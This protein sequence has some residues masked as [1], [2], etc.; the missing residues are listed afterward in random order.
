[1]LTNQTANVGGYITFDIFPVL[2]EGVS[3][4]QPI[5]LINPAG[6]FRLTKDTR[7]FD[8]DAAY[9]FGIDLTCEEAL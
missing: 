9:I 7:Q 8:M 2:R 3:D 1:V 5:T 4:D 6:T